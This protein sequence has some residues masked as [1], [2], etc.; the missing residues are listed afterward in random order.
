[1]PV[2]RKCFAP[3]ENNTVSVHSEGH[4]VNFDSALFNSQYSVAPPIKTSLTFSPEA[5]SHHVGVFG[6]GSAY[7]TL[8]LYQDVLGRRDT[9]IVARGAP[10]PL[11]L[12]SGFPGRTYEDPIALGEA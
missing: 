10:T 12:L 5:D 3:S 8:E 9:I 11:W 1:M 7:P 2:T 4:S 6:N